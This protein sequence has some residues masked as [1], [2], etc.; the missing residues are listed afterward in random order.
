LTDKPILYVG[1]RGEN[2]T[3]NLAAEKTLEEIAKREGAEFL[4]LCTKLEAEIVELSEAD[5]PAFLADLGMKE[6]GLE[7]IILRAHKLLKLI[8][9]FTAGEDECR[10]WT[11][12]EGSPAPK[13]AGKIHSDIERG[14][15][16]AEIYRFEDIDRLH[17]EA[18][19][20][21]AGLMRS[22]GKSYVVKDGDVCYFKFAV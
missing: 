6:T 5:R 10:A 4:S 13:A 19:I 21:E 18:A 16:R 12:G 15:I 22:E 1:N 14:F 11:V 2:G 3:G 17:T 8:S 20:R 9:F 7:R